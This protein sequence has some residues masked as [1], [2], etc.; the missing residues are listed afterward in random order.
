M[1]PANQIQITDLTD[2]G[3]EHARTD[4]TLASHL[5]V[6]QRERGQSDEA[7][8]A[9]LGLTRDEWRALRGGEGRWH[10]VALARAL[11]HFPDA[12]PLAALEVRRRL[13][14]GDGWRHWHATDDVR[15]A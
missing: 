14:P 12:L 1:F 8:A 13:E 6:Q 2:R 11:L 4:E 7:F 3:E 10:A 9:Q 15:A 5:A